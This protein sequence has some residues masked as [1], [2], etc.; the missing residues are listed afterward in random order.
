NNCKETNDDNTAEETIQK[1]SFLANGHDTDNVTPDN[2]ESTLP[3]LT[4][5]IQQMESNTTLNCDDSYAHKHNHND[6][7]DHDHD[8]DHDHGSVECKH[9]ANDKHTTDKNTLHNVI[10]LSSSLSSKSKW[11]YDPRDLLPSDSDLIAND[12]PLANDPAYAHFKRFPALTNTND[13]CFHNIIALDCEMVQT[14]TALELA[15]IA[16]LDESGQCIYNEYIK[17]EN[18]VIDYYT[19]F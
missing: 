3:A 9:S 12:F 18:P 14:T 13:H 16:V 15:H 1:T 2:H 17:P 7:H 19:K 5:Q 10:P 4:E 6:N 8:H 11:K